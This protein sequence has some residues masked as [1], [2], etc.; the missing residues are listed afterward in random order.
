MKRF[1]ITLYSDPGHAWGKLK[2]DVLHG[3]NVAHLITRYSYT[4]GDNVYLEE[5]CDL[6]VVIKALEAQGC[7]VAFKEKHTDK[8][9]RIRNYERYEYGF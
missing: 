7:T 2:L 6:S 3:L 8:E 9:S 4:Y 1:T 5:D